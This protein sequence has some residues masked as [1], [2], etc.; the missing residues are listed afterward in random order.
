MGKLGN[1]NPTLIRHDYKRACYRAMLSEF[2]A[3]EVKEFFGQVPLL[4]DGKKFEGADLFSHLWM[5]KASIPI[6]YD[7]ALDNILERFLISK[8]RSVQKVMEKVLWL[9]N[10]STYIPGKVLL[11]WFYP[12]LESVFHSIDSRDMVFAMIPLFTENFL[13]NHIHRRVKKWEEGDFVNSIMVYISDPSYNEYMDWDL[14]FIAGPQVIYAP[15]MFGLPPFE[16]FGMISDCRTPDRIVWVQE[17]LP[18]LVADDVLIGKEVYG[19]KTFFSEF[20]VENEID[21]SRYNP[22]DLEGVI[23]TRDYFCMQ[24]KRV[25][26]HKGCFY[27]APVF[28]HSVLHRRLNQRPKGLLSSFIADLAREEGLQQDELQRKH[29][30]LLATLGEKAVFEFHAPTESMVLNGEHFTRGISAVILKHLLEAY[31]HSSK[32]EFEYKELKRV[33]EIN[34]GQKNSNFEVRFYRLMDKLV[35]SCKTLR[36]EKTGRGKFKLVVNGTLEFGV[37]GNL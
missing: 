9:N 2:S 36:I 17:D 30:L 12:K 15:V 35:E 16:G 31:V 25:V 4:M 18:Q 11:T 13:P 20:L 5:E 7:Y 26:L 34:L 1:S 37:T 14:E 28:L 29:N 33:F 21:L 27:G 10:Q 22:P 3:D 6:C 8:G 32:K 19:K 24:R 23:I